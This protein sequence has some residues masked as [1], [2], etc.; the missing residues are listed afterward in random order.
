MRRTLFRNLRTDQLPDFVLPLQV[1]AQRFRVIYE[2]AA[3]LE[4]DALEDNASEFRMRVR[5]ALRALWAMRDCAELLSLRRQ[6]LFAWQ[7]WSHKLLR[8]LA[9]LPLAVALL[10]VIPLAI[11][12]PPYRPILLIAALALLLALAEIPW[13]WSRATARLA[14]FA[15]YFVLL[16]AACAVAALRFARGERITLWKP[17]TG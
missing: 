15:Q 8:Y 2:P 17:R 5:V 16:N 14:R 9:F 12:A 11:L 7:L 6:P 10:L 13:Q 1:V 3:T 4:E